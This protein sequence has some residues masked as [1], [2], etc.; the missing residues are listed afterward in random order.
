MIVHSKYLLSGKFISPTV[1]CKTCFDSDSTWN[2]FEDISGNQLKIR[3]L[4]SS[5]NMKNDRSNFFDLLNLKNIFKGRFLLIIL[6][7]TDLM[8]WNVLLVYSSQCS[9]W[10][11]HFQR[12]WPNVFVEISTNLRKIW[13]I[14]RNH[15]SLVKVCPARVAVNPILKMIFMQTSAK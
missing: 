14:Q 12:F 4:S 11:W 10:K 1:I 7:R 13:I 9:M 6:S 15:L 3:E 5:N 8:T 2:I